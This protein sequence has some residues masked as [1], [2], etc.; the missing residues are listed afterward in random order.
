[1]RVATVYAC[2]RIRS[3]IVANM[4]I[5]I[6]RRIDDRTREDA[7]DLPLWRILRRK[8]NGWQTAAQFKRMMQAHLLLRGNAYAVIGMIPVRWS[9]FIENKYLHSDFAGYSGLSDQYEISADPTALPV[10]NDE[11]Q[12]L[13]RVKL[14]EGKSF[15]AYDGVTIFLRVLAIVLLL[16]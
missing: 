12:E 3:G 11:G 6:K 14:R 16:A 8:P 13:F 4:P 10:R 1:M 15:I 2:V 7:S 9:Y 5:H